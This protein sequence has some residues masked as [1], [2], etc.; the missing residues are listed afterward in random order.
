MAIIIYVQ[1]IEKRLETAK[2]LKS[3]S[4]S[5]S[6]LSFIIFSLKINTIQEMV[7]PLGLEPRTYPL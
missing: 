6:V 7:D 3:L 2:I 1:V 4:A 5:F